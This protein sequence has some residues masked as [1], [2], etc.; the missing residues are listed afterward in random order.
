MPMLDDPEPH[1]RATRLFHAS[2]AAAIVAQ[3]ATSQ[4]MRPPEVGAGSGRRAFLRAYCSINGVTDIPC[5][6]TEVATI[7][8][9]YA[10]ISSASGRDKP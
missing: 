1:S 2:L 4:V 10:M 7:S 9:V 6:T 5:N 8:N 3:L